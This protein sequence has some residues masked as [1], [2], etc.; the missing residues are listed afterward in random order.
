MAHEHSILG[1]LFVVIS[2]AGCSGVPEGREKKKIDSILIETVDTETNGEIAGSTHFHFADA[3][4]FLDYQKFENSDLAK[5]ELDKTE[6]S[7]K[8]VMNRSE[9]QDESGTIEGKIVKIQK[10]DDIASFCVVW[11]RRSKVTSVCSS[12][13]EAI[14]RFIDAYQL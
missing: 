3:E 6:R 9:L 7:A 8:S 1:L 2:I 11:S 13:H 5:L 14:D 10:S 4:Y 12:S